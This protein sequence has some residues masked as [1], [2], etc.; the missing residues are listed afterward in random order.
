MALQDDLQQL[1]ALQPQLFNKL[2]P[3]AVTPPMGPPQ[4]TPGGAV[5]GFFPQLA[6]TRQSSYAADNAMRAGVNGAG[7]PAV[8]TLPP[9]QQGLPAGVA[10]STAGAG[11]GSVNPVVTD[12]VV[13]TAP[14]AA[15]TPVAASAAK[16]ASRSAMPKSGAAPAPA[17]AAAPPLVA[18]V[19]GMQVNNGPVLPWGTT[20]DAN[21]N[22]SYS[23][24]GGQGGAGGAAAGGYDMSGLPGGGKMVKG[25]G[26]AMQFADPR[27]AVVFGRQQQMAHAQDVINLIL[28]NAGSGGDLG[29]HAKI[30]ALA[31][32]VGENNFGA[33]A[34]SGT[35]TLNDEIGRITGAR[36][37]AG[38]ELG[39]AG[40]HLEGTREEIE[41]GQERHFSTAQPAGQIVH[42]DKTGTVP[43]STETTM[44]VPQRGGGMVP[45]NPSVDR[46]IPGVKVG[47]TTKAPD[48]EHPLL[49]GQTATVKGGKIT[50]IK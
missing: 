17:A 10:P 5:F 18:G 1:P 24:V 41:A 14:Q 44:A 3:G 37:G 38:A 26:G 28:Q 6:G 4:Q 45:I 43:L 48:G 13:P 42:Y 21:G 30:A 47:A 16:P 19:D 33:L 34:M 31:H 22:G 7:Q 35:N 25:V 49:N 36:I 39:V 9:V 50:E 2:P 8:A 23:V 46:P 40:M 20:I 29:Y 12:P 27:D 11:R 15:A 32:A